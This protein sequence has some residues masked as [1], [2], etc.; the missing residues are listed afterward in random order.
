MVQSVIFIGTAQKQLLLEKLLADPT[1]QRVSRL[2]AHEAR[3]DKTSSALAGL[4][5]G[6]GHPWQQSQRSASGR[7]P[8]LRRCGAR[9]HRNRHRCPRYP[10]ESVTHVINYDL[11]NV[12]ESYVHRIGRTARAGAA[13]IAISFCNGEERAYLRD[14]EKLTRMSVPAAPLPAGIQTGVEAAAPDR[15]ARRQGQPQK[16][17]RPQQA[18]GSR[19]PERSRS[20]NRGGK[21]RQGKQGRQP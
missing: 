18:S 20:G 11:P 2:Y 13:G 4:H 19:K 6:L 1:M 8:P 12:P 21:R 15:A 9:A 3:R 16:H 7:S 10:R 14:I 17:R 5:R